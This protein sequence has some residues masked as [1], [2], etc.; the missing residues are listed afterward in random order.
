MCLYITKISLFCYFVFFSIVNDKK[1]E[2]GIRWRHLLKDLHRFHNFLM[3]F[4]L[5]Y[6][7]LMANKFSVTLLLRYRAN[8]AEAFFNDSMDVMRWISCRIACKPQ[9][10]QKLKQ[11]VRP[12]VT[13]V[14]ASKREQ[15]FPLWT[16]ARRSFPSGVASLHTH[17]HTYVCWKANTKQ[18]SEER[19]GRW[20]LD[21]VGEL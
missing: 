17:T 20:P 9:P 1:N 13:I 8:S 2:L 12:P 15:F 6:S 4:V 7:G 3:S 11:Q 19:E 14:L 5:L 10:E 16:E 18:T 21:H